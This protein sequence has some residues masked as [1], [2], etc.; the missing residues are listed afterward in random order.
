MQ[1]GQGFVLNNA[2]YGEPLGNVYE[3]LEMYDSTDT[4]KIGDYRD[5]VFYEDTVIAVPVAEPDP[6]DPIT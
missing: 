5:L 6:E 3:V 2:P 1:D 4:T